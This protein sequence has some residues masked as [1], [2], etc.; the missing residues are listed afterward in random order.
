MG[1]LHGGGN[2]QLSACHIGIGF[3][4]HGVAVHLAA[5]GVE[6]KGTLDTA[7]IEE[8]IHIAGAGLDKVAVAADGV[9]QLQIVRSGKGYA[10][11]GHI[12]QHLGQQLG[13]ALVQRGVGQLHK[14]GI[15]HAGLL[16]HGIVKRGHIHLIPALGIPAIEV[17][18]LLG[19]Q[20]E[21]EDSVGGITPHGE[22]QIHGEHRLPFRRGHRAGQIQPACYHRGI[23][24]HIGIKLKRSG[25]AGDHIVV[26]LGRKREIAV[27]LLDLLLH[28]QVHGIAAGDLLV[29][30]HKGAV[31]GLIL[32]HPIIG[33]GVGGQNGIYVIDDDR[34]HLAVPAYIVAQR[35]GQQAERNIGAVLVDIGGH[36]TLDMLHNLGLMP[37]GVCRGISLIPVGNV[38]G[39]NGELNGQISLFGIPLKGGIRH[40]GLDGGD[41]TGGAIPGH[42]LLCKAQLLKHSHKGQAGAVLPD[43]RHC[44]GEGDVL[45]ID[46]HIEVP[47]LGGEGIVVRSQSGQRQKGG[48]HAGAQQQAKMLFHTR[49][50]SQIE[51]WYL[52][53]IFQKI[54]SQLRSS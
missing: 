34:C 47:L 23:H 6:G 14:L 5:A 31:I 33:L 15:G 7:L 25:A 1:A 45:S 12:L 43:L 28:G 41:R 48:G 11:K 2:G 18:Q 10:V 44:I 9:E 46:H 22:A 8:G 20:L 54:L 37:M 50:L 13:E 53:Y 21:V 24:G 30:L 40:I 36:F 26:A 16:R 39:A 3:Q 29:F 38:V 19:I 4:L 49:L 35:V 51:D 32:I 17:P 27:G 52:N 42:I